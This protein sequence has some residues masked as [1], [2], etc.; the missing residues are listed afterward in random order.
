[1]RKKLLALLM[2][3]TMV[4][5]T[6]VTAFAA[7]SESDAKKIGGE[8][9]NNFMAE[10]WKADQAITSTTSNGANGMVTYG[11]LEDNNTDVYHAYTPVVV[12]KNSKSATGYSQATKLSAVYDNA[13]G[14]EL[15]K[16][17]TAGEN[18]VDVVPSLKGAKVYTGLKNDGTV[19]KDEEVVVSADTTIAG[20]TSYYDSNANLIFTVGTTNQASTDEVAKA[21]ADAA[22]GS[23]LAPNDKYAVYVQ[24]IGGSKDLYLVSQGATSATVEK[25]SAVDGTKAYV[26]TKVSDNLVVAKKDGIIKSTDEN[27]FGT[28]WSTVVAAGEKFTDLDNI[29][30]AIDNEVFTKD[31]V[32][33]KVSAYLQSSIATDD[34]LALEN[35]GSYMNGLAKVLWNSTKIQGGQFTFDSD[36][37]SRTG[38][39]GA[40][41][42]N[43]FTVGYA[44]TEL[45]QN[46]GL[47]V[48][49]NKLAT[50]KVDSTI[51]F[52]KEAV[53]G[54][55]IFVFDKGELAEEPTTDNNDGVSDAATTAPA[56]T[57]NTAASPKTGDV[58]P[59]AALA[60]VMMGA[61]GA[62]VVASKK[63]A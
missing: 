59:I 3:A 54:D 27:A 43:V 29:Q 40:D 51:V 6:G 21:A 60:V 2:C 55:G 22:K 31:A 32:A 20:T 49:F 25:T 1:M 38:F 14:Y 11:Y 10:Y 23:A 53:Y 46:Y 52:D 4:L 61:C 16:N 18:F 56:A 24:T 30:A 34:S 15:A 50:V 7:T 19:D 47:V 13:T 57:N 41:A 42:V 8:N 58:A 26:A 45:D 37:I 35:T 44:R 33:V 17:A 9:A 63:R 36:L 5:G 39:K 62:M 48:P 12:Y 28:I